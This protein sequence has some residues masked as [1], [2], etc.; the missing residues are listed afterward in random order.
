[1]PMGF[2]GAHS[3]LARMYEAEAREGLG[4]FDGAAQLM[5]P[6]LAPDPGVTASFF[7]FTTFQLLPLAVRPPGPGRGGLE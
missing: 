4:D 7:P 2:L 5:D 1:M 6:A 3:F